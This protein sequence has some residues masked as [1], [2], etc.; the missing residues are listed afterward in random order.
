[1]TVGDAC[2][3]Y[4][5]MKNMRADLRIVIDEEDFSKEYSV[6]V[7]ETILKYLDD[8]IADLKAMEVVY[9]DSRRED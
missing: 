5:K 8:L 6:K 4:A 1:M 7:L 2:T 9:H 3:L